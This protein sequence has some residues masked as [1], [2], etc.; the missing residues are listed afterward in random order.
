MASWIMQTI[1]LAEGNIPAL[2][3]DWREDTLT[4]LR[5]DAPKI[6][7]VLVMAYLLTRMARSEFG[8]L[9][10]GGGRVLAIADWVRRH[11]EYRYGTTDAMTSAF[12]T[13]TE[14]VGV[15]LA[16]VALLVTCASRAEAT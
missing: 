1:A 7:F 6:V 2:L 10:R 4:F 12:D 16:S 9:P 8:Y 14:R 3:R 15:C 13:A 5:H 11:V